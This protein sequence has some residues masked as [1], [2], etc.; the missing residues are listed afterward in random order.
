MD[1]VYD[2][3][4]LAGGRGTRLGGAD[5][6][7]VTVGGESLL[8]RT[9][10][11]VSAART[12]VVVGEPDP[13]TVPGPVRVVQ[14]SPRHG[15]PVAAIAAGLH[16]VDAAWT[17]VAA[18]DHPFL[19]DAPTRLTDAVGRSGSGPD[20]ADGAVA[21]AGSTG[22]RFLLVLA[23]TDRLTR[24]LADLGEPA[25]RSVGELLRRLDLTD[26]PVG[27]QAALD[28]DTWD[29]RDQAESLDAAP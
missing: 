3:V 11:A 20:E 18:C 21:V 5:K 4:V 23:R 27:E 14:E 25:G 1:T 9:L 16:E 8:R 7:A 24:A 26:V 2:A 17:L 19:A 12:V 29:D 28:V 22:R 13:S 15:G 10:G 6:A